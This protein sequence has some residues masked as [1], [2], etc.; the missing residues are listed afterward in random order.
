MFQQ[1]LMLALDDF[2]S[3]DAA[4][5]VH[6]HPFLVSGIHFEARA[7]NGEVRRRDG[8]LDK[9]PHLLDVF[10][11]DV[12]ERIEILHFSRDAAR[13]LRGVKSGN[14]AY[15]ALAASHCLPCVLGADPHG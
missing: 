3:S 12:L 4:T 9:S 8:E 11:L 2:E 5:D 15:A 10:L 1:S 14:R 7:G 13:K 6:S